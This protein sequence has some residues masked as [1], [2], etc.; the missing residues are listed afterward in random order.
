[1]ADN[2]STLKMEYGMRYSWYFPIIS[3]EAGQKP[4]YGPKIDMGAAVKAALSVTTASASIAADDIT[5]L[6]LEQ[7]VSAQLDA[8]TTLSDLEVNAKIYGHEYTEKGGEV[9]RSRDVSPNGGYAFVQSMM[10][11]NKNTFFRATC[12]HKV[13]AMPSSERQEGNTKKSG[14]I[15]MNPRSVS[16]KVMEDATGVWR[17]RQDF[18]QISEAV[19]F[20]ESLY[21]AAAAQ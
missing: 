14:E 20:I 12:L 19:T 17:T 2:K 13:C 5:Q 7:F 1:M 15:T 11:K 10:D 16:F 18:P 3:E 6:E 21:T 9:S 8:E 4:V